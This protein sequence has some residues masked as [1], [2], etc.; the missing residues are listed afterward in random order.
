MA[1][2]RETTHE[3]QL[4]QKGGPF[5]VVQVAKTEPGPDQIR[6][7]LQAIALNLLDKKQRDMGIFIKEYPFV[8]GIEGAGVVETVGSEVKDFQPGDEVMA[9]PSGRM[10]GENWGGAY[11]ERTNVQVDFYTARKPKNIS[12]EE[13][14]SL[15]I[16]YVTAV[17]VMANE[18]GIPLP[19]LPEL[20]NTGTT[21]SSVLVL[22]GSSTTGAAAIQLLRLAHPSLPIYAT[23]SARNFPQVN[24]IGATK[25]FD[26]HSPSLV[27]DIKAHSPNSQG[28]DMIL[29]FVAGGAAQTDICDVFD[30]AGSKQYRAVLTGSTI[31]V[32]E[33][34]ALR[35]GS[36]HE[37]GEMKGGKSIFPMLTKLVEEGKYKVPLKADI[38]GHGLEDI[39]K[40]IED[41]PKVSAA[42]IIVTV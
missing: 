9:M 8:L 11:A 19:I 28:I 41:L 24:S 12:V 15:P 40:V 38:R 21:P 34:V 26:Y 5:K 29:D 3:L 13:A 27:A 16:A 4:T 37:I 23:S 2:S 10:T 35:V 42:K 7:R 22:G 14:A 17:A 30:P 33:G 32:P 31:P 1:N 36:G 20:D 6:V 18:S 39:P 25:V